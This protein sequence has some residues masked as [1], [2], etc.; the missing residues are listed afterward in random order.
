MLRD[1]ADQSGQ[2]VSALLLS[3]LSNGQLGMTLRQGCEGVL[4]LARKKL[5]LQRQA[6]T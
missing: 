2:G 1:S 3:E 5:D 4:R 6:L